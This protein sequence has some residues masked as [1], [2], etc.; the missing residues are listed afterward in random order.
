MPRGI[1]RVVLMPS[2][3]WEFRLFRGLFSSCRG[4]YRDAPHVVLA[5]ARTDLLGKESWR[6]PG[7]QG[8]SARDSGLGVC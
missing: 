3:H 6:V 4:G 1:S 5:V 7:S 8:S 2:L